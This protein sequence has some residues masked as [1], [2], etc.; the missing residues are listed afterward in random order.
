MASKHR[1]RVKCKQATKEILQRMFFH[2]FARHVFA[3]ASSVRFCTTLIFIVLTPG[4]ASAAAAEQ[5]FAY[6]TAGVGA[7]EIARLKARESEF[8]V[9]LVFTLMEG[10]YLSD[11]AVVVNDRSGNPVLVLAAPGPMVLAKLPP[12]AYVVQATYEGRTVTRKLDVRERLRTEYLRWP[13]NPET[14]FPGPKG[15]ERD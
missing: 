12:G 2:R 1:S 8:N 13:S 9:K 5:P 7:D 14:D 6:A 10:N 11:V 4:A 15:T 3:L